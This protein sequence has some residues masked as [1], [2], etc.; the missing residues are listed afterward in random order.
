[1]GCP[2]GCCKKCKRYFRPICGSDGKTYNNK[3]F[4]KAAACKSDSRIGF[5][6]KGKCGECNVKCGSD[7][8]KDPKKCLSKC[9]PLHCKKAKDRKRCINRCRNAY[10]AYMSYDMWMNKCHS[11]WWKVYFCTK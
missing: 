5:W 11:Y 6:Y 10:I 9:C 2:D 3:C 4:M 7:G 1:M 8:K